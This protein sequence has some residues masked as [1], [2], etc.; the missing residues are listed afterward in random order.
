MHRSRRVS[1][2]ATIRKVIIPTA[3]TFRIGKPK[4][5]ADGTIAIPKR[6]VAH[7]P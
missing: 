5:A 7:G 4:V 2:S 1:K 6:H 3:D